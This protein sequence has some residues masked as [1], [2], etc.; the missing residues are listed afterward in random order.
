MLN[1]FS[2]TI[3]RV[4]PIQI[5]HQFP[6]WS[7]PALDFCY[8][9]NMLAHSS[10]STTHRQDFVQTYYEEFRA[11]LKKIGYRG[12]VPTLLD[13][14]IEI[15]KCSYAEFMFAISFVPPRF[16]DFSKLDFNAMFSEPDGWK[17]MTAMGYENPEYISFLK[18]HFKRHL[19]LGTL[20]F[21]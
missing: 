5:D 8:V 14:H 12:R 4:C 1:G 3:K 16:I 19:Y 10:L 7:S 20:N 17:I 13:L 6:N 2:L 9:F 18:G 11:T 15:I 21:Q